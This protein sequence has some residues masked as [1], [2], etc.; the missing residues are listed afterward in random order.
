MTPVTYAISANIDY[1]AALSTIHRYF[2]EKR[3][4]ALGAEHIDIFE[5]EL[6]S[7]EKRL[8]DNPEIYSMHDDYP[9][10]HY[11]KNYRSFTIH[12]FYHF[13]HL[14]PVRRCYHLAYCVFKIRSL[15]YYSATL[16]YAW[17]YLHS[18]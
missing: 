13:L 4:P 5:K 11:A 12:W 8:A 16:I 6:R 3:L 10:L 9:A 17:D 18:N 1:I 2:A 7:A 15:K 14:R